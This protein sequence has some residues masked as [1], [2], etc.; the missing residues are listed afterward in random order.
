MKV[1]VFVLLAV[2]L[3]L[4]GCATTANYEKTCASWI[5]DKEDSLISSWGPPQSTY[6]LSDGSRVIQ[7]VREGNAQVGGLTYTAPQTTYNNGVI[8]GY[9][10]SATYNGTSTQ[11]VEQTTPVYNIHLSCITRFTIDSSGIIQSYSF[12]GNNCLALPPK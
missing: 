7:Y 1:K 10:G 3:C 5:G 9:G 2:I 11:F 6:T 12:E 4:A 8:N